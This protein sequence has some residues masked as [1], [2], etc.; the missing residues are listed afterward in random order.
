MVGPAA[1]LLGW[2]H[3]EWSD[4]VY[5]GVRGPKE[6]QSNQGESGC[7][8]VYRGEF[9]GGKYVGEG[10]TVKAYYQG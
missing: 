6:N 4:R 10:V 8:L 2:R 9:V 7:R 5:V 3:Q 1:S